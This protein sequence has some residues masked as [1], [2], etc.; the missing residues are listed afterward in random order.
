MLEDELLVFV[1]VRFRGPN[2]YTDGAASITPRKVSRILG[3]A[4][5]FLARNG[6]HAHRHCRF[7]VVSVSQRDYAPS[8]GHPFGFNWIRDAFGA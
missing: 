3:A 6:A 2:A 4:H 5:L 1:E 7:D 8:C